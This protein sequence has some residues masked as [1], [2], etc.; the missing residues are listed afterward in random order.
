M[1]LTRVYVDKELDS[2]SIVELPRET[3]QHLVKVLRTRNGD[4]IVLF[5]GDGREYAGAIEG[6]RGSRVTAAVG[7]ATNVDRESPLGIT[8]I[9]CIPHSG[10]GASFRY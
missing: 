10:F 8:L 2:G 6:V 5:N 7:E 3:A 4:Q 1:R 9:Q